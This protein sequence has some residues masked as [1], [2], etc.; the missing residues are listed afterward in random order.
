[1]NAVEF[2][3]KP[4][5]ERFLLFMM[6]N[7]VAFNR[8][9]YVDQSGIYGFTLEEQI[10]KVD[11]IGKTKDYYY[12]IGGG[13]KFGDRL[14]NA[15]WCHYAEGEIHAIT[16]PGGVGNGTP[17][18]MITARQDGCHFGVGSPAI[19]GSVRVAHANVQFERKA[20]EIIQRYQIKA[21]VGEDAKLW[22][23]EGGGM[24]RVGGKVKASTFGIRRGNE[25]KFYSQV[26]DTTNTERYVL[27]GVYPI[28]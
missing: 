6:D 21:E 16:L 22:G 23:P 7:I 27:K 24:I 13:L 10:K 19:D 20:A 9:G 4:S 15:Y 2:L 1:M 18:I 14:F 25:W 17:D 28:G 8:P 11:L 12:F 3:A 5:A 26:Y